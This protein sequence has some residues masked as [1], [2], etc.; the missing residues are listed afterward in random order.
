VLGFGEAV[1]IVQ[2]Q[3]L[4]QSGR[5]GCHPGRWCE[6]SMSWQACVESNRRSSAKRQSLAGPAQ[7]SVNFIS[8]KHCACIIRRVAKATAAAGA[9][10]QCSKKEWL[11]K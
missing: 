10:P 4:K 1:T 7:V 6:C 9:A 8:N 5:A 2:Q 3:Q 11:Y